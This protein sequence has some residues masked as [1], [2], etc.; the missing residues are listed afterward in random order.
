MKI[1]NNYIF[2]INYQNIFECID[3]IYYPLLQ[4]LETITS[5]KSTID[6]TLTRIDYCVS[7]SSVFEL[8]KNNI[9]NNI[10]EFVEELKIY[11]NIE[12]SLILFILHITLEAKIEYLDSISEE[13]IIII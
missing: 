4:N 2:E 13:D 1:D 12:F 7:H 9:K 5:L 6:N 8:F 10:I 3:Q 11:E